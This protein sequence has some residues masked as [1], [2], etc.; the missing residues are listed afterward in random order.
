[1]VVSEVGSGGKSLFDRGNAPISSSTHVT[2]FKSLVIFFAR[3]GVFGCN[4]NG[5]CRR[6]KDEPGLT[7]RWADNEEKV[8]ADSRSIAP[9]RP[10]Q[11]LRTRTPAA[12]RIRCGRLE[13]RHAE[14]HLGNNQ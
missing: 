5:Q 7:G 12:G 9:S 3:V 13:G 10:A 4:R 14:M 11:G 6:E 8:L 2:G 1:M